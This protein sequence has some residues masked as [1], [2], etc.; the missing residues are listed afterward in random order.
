MAFEGFTGRD[1]GSLADAIGIGVFKDICTPSI[2]SGLMTGTVGPLGTATSL[3]VAGIVPTAMSGMMKAKGAQNGFT[4][5]DLSKLADAISNGVCDVLMTMVLT[6]TTVGLA[7]G[8]GTANFVGLDENEL[9]A[10]IKLALPEFTGRDILNLTDMIAAGIVMHLMS[11][12]VFTVVVVGI[13]SP[14]PPVGPIAI[15][16]IPIVVPVVS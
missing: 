16:G 8:G 10:D 4:G 15:T 3:S 2:T 11:S 12:A 13:V 14:V 1:M 7:V 9:S 6:G 5:R